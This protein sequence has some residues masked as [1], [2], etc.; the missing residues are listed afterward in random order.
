VLAP[1]QRGGLLTGDGRTMRL[2]RVEFTNPKINAA[3]R[4]LLLTSG[5]KYDTGLMRQLD[6]PWREDFGHHRYLWAAGRGEDVGVTFA[7]DGL[8]AGMNPAD[9]RP[10]GL[11]VGLSRWSSVCRDLGAGGAG[12]G[13]VEDALV[14]GER[15]DQ[16]LDCEVVHRAG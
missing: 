9:R 2:R 16:G 8:L 14:G 6:L 4:S 12:G 13:L 7:D 3:L 11:V 5:R 1:T 10:A 15:R